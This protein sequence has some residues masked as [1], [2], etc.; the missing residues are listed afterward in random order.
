MFQASYTGYQLNFHRP[1]GTS[2]GVLRRKECWYLKL[3]REDG[4]TGIGE[5]SFI[6]GLSLEDPDEIEIQVDHICKLIGRGE[7]DPAQSLPSLPGIQFA[8]ETALKD[9]G[10]GGCRILFPSD[11]TE[12]H[13]GIP[14]NGLIWMGNRSYLQEQIRNK[15]ERGFRVLKMKVGAMGMEA[16]LEVLAW[17]RSEYGSGDLEVRLDANGAWL[18]ED[19]PGRMDAFARYGIHSIEQPIRQGQ[20]EAMAALCVDPAIPVA[21]DEELIGVVGIANKK[22][23]LERIK[24]SYI[25]LK[26]GLLGGFSVANEWIDLANELGAGWWITSALES[27][28]GLNAIAQWTYNLGVSMPQGL[29]TGQLY[30]NN[31]PSPLQMEG[32]RLWYRAENHWGLQSIFNT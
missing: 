24:P 5:V 29:G 21:L 22:Q 27:S 32:D 28:I 25:I 26:P 18:P 31:L 30:T 12:G 14:T 13:A 17:I 4:L 23:L 3:T 11:F 7:M 16:E 1:A 2:R 6:P 9:L 8:M 10:H 15:M 20:V 19:A